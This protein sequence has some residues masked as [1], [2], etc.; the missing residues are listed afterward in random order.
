VLVLTRSRAPRLLAALAAVALLATAGCSS[1]GAAVDNPVATVNG[2]DLS[3]DW[4]DEVTR[5]ALEVPAGSMTMATS[6]SSSILDLLI[7]VELVR[8]SVDDLGI[9]L[10]EDDRQAAAEVLYAQ[11]GRDQ[12][13]G[14]VDLEAGQAAFEDLDEVLQEISID[15]QMLGDALAGSVSDEDAGV[16]PVTDADVEAAYEQRVPEL[17]RRCISYIGSDPELGDLVQQADA[18]EVY[19]RLVAGEEIEALLAEVN[20][21][22]PEDQPLCAEFG[23]VTQAEMQEQVSGGQFPTELFEAIWAAEGVGPIEPVSPG[24]QGVYVFHVDSEEVTPLA[25]VEE[26]IRAELESANDDLRNQVVGGLVAEMALAA[27]VWID[28]K[29]GRWVAVDELGAE[30]TDVEAAVGAG[31]APPQGPQDPPVDPDSTLPVDP[32]G[33]LGVPAAP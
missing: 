18:D 6:E 22:R 20:E 33:G 16:V 7:Q 27:D 32:L 15:Q 2:V 1:G 28:P 19:E 21:G 10:T 31:V 23:C 14:V 8:Q 25:D 3:A 4:V 11:L 29:Y 12:T 5:A 26:Q 13:T 30:T 24:G 9:E 17:T